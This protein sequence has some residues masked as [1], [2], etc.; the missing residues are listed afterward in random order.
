[1]EYSQILDIIRK[2]LSKTLICLSSE[3]VNSILDEQCT[4]N[5]FSTDKELQRCSL[6]QI[7]AMFRTYQSGLVSLLEQFDLDTDEKRLSTVVELI[8]ENSGIYIG[9]LNQLKRNVEHLE[10]WM[11]TEFEILENYTKND[12]KTDLESCVNF[13]FLADES[14][15]SD[16]LANTNLSDIT[17]KMELRH[18]ALE[19]LMTDDESQKEKMISLISNRIIE[20]AI[21]N[22]EP[23]KLSYFFLK[24]LQDRD[25]HIQSYSELKGC[26]FFSPL[27]A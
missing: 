23:S 3:R 22:N 24:K 20:K 5:F 19:I 2:F 1:M 8:F 25:L 6:N 26:P 21:L 13:T 4:S 7:K 18:K 9:K 27:F 17:D 16:I 10:S 11:Q 12:L 15:I 14:V